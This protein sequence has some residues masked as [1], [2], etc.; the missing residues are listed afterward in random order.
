M[1]ATTPTKSTEA[2][3]TGIPTLSGSTSTLQAAMVP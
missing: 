3:T 1:S 2:V